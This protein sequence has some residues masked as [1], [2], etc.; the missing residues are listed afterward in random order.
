MNYSFYD[1]M[2]ELNEI[3]EETTDEETFLETMMDLLGFNDPKYGVFMEKKETIKYRIKSFKKRY[4]FHKTNPEGTIGAILINGIPVYVDLDINNY[5]TEDYERDASA[6]YL[7]EVQQYMLVLNRSFFELNKKD[8]DALVQHEMGHMRLKPGNPS[9]QTANERITDKLIIKWIQNFSNK[10]D[11]M[12][13][14]E[15]M[16][17]DERKV[18]IDNFRDAMEERIETLYNAKRTPPDMEKLRDGMYDYAEKYVQKLSK[19]YKFSVKGNGT[20]QSLHFDADE[21]EADR[22]AANHTSEKQVT[23]AIINYNKQQARSR[24]RSKM[25]KSMNQIRKDEGRAP[26]SDAEFNKEISRNNKEHDADFIMRKKAL[27][28]DKMKHSKVYKNI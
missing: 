8:Q 24:N 4:D 6:V 3:L 10:V 20:I 23:R 17:N 18:V 2:D 19:K 27:N 11:T 12:C 25:R 15:G 26:I 16:T 5:D 28:D 7:D 21:M 13:R 14:L 9:R 1:E 22:Y